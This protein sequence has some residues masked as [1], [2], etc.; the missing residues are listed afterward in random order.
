MLSIIRKGFIARCPIRNGV[1]VSVF[2]I[3]NQ[4]S[5]AKLFTGSACGE[6]ACGFHDNSSD[7]G[8]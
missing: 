4:A 1:L 5:A 3:S 2:D 8:R 6:K 7:S